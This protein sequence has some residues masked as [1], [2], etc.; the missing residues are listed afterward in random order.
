MCMCERCE[1]M[2]CA[3]SKP[4]THACQLTITQTTFSHHNNWKTTK[5][6]NSPT[7]VNSTIA[8][9]AEM[10]PTQ[11]FRENVHKIHFRGLYPLYFDY[12]FGVN[13]LSKAQRRI[14]WNWLVID[15][16]IIH[17]EAD[18]KPTS[19]R[20]APDGFWADYGITTERR[21]MGLRAE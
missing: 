9:F 10:S 12:N 5:S 19:D 15:T 18:T 4:F 14:I 11:G 6:S 1:N 21:D 2:R 13:W 8:V 3:Q 17:R 7:S 20:Y 16:I